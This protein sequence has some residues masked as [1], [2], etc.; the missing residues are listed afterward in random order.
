MKC[1][2]CGDRMYVMDS[3]GEDNITYRRYVCKNCGSYLYTKEQQDGRA[4]RI[5][6]KISNEAKKKED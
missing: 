2:K 1:L 4:K 6:C 5:I 3:R